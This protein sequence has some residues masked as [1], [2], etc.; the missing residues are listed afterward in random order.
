MR[1]SYISVLFYILISTFTTVAQIVVLDPTTAG[2]EDPVTII[3]DANQGNKELVGASKVYIHHGVVTDKPDGTAWKYVKGNWGADD[4]IGLMTR[5]EGEQNKW[6]FT[7]NPNIRSYFGVPASENIY[8]ISCVFRSADGTKKGTAP[9]GQFGWGTIASNLDIFINLNSGDFIQIN[10]PTGNYGLY[11][12]GQSQLVSATASSDVSE[13][14]LLIDEGNGFESKTMVT[15]GKT[16]Q[17]NYQ[18]TTSKTLKIRVT[19]KINGADVDFEKSYDVVVKN[20][21][22]NEPRPAGTLQGANYFSDPTKIRLSLLAPQK[23]LV[24]VVGDFTDWK[25]QEKYQMKKD[26]EYFWLD[27]DGLTPG[28]QYVYQYWIDGNLHI[29]DPYAQQIADPWNDKWIESFVFPNLPPYSREDLGIASVLQTSQPQ[30]TWS[31]QES[32][33][34]K[35]DVN[36]LVIYELHIRDFLGSHSYKDLTDTLSY[37]KRLGINAIELMPINEFEGNDSW[38]YNPSFYFAVDKYYGSKNDLKR[39]IDVAHQHGMAVILDIVL[40]H[41]FGQSPMVQMYFDKSANKPTANNPWFYRDYVGPFEWGYDFNHDSPYTKQFVDDVNTF[42]LREFHFDGF[43]FDFTKGFTSANHPFD[44]YNASRIGILKRMADKIR[45]FDPEAY[46]ILE[47]WGSAS[48]ETELANYGMKMWANRSYD[49]VPA[50]IGNPSTGSFVNMFANSH[51][52]FFNSHDERR[53]AEHCL[54]EGRSSGAYNVKT[55]EIMYERVK[56][57]AAFTYLQPGPKMI[58][59]FD[60]LGYDIDINLNGRT[61]RKPLPWGA[62]S[63]RY[64]ED[65]LRQHIYTTYQAVINL[66]NTITPQKLASATR[67]FTNT[68]NVRKITYTSNDFDLIVYGNFSMS[69][70]NFTPNFPKP[71]VWHQHMTG[72]S[73]VIINVNQ[74]FTLKPGEWHIYTTKKY[75]NGFPGAVEVFDNPVTIAPFPFTL[76]QEIT[77]TFDAK[78]A[79]KKGSAGLVGSDKVYYHS[80]TI[81]DVSKPNQWQTT[82]GTLTDDGLGVMTNLGNDL[83]Q[84]KIKARDYYNVPSGEDI[85]QLGMFFRDADNTNFGYGFRNS[86]IAV[87]V[88]STEPIVTINPAGFQPNTPITITFHADRGNRELLNATKIYMHSGVSLVNNQTPQI[89]GWQKVVGNWG[90]DDGVGAMTKVPGTNRWELKIT[91]KTYYNLTNT[92]FPYWITA[93]FRNAD[94]SIKGTGPQGPMENGFIDS[95]LDFFIKNAITVSNDEVGFDDLKIHPNPASDILFISS[96]EMEKL[97]GIIYN[98]LGQQMTGI[99]SADKNGIDISFLQP[100]TYWVFI[101]NNNKFIARSFVKF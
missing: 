27:I 76:D 100:G 73:I 6:K 86:V 75:S 30:Y 48:E 23:N 19:A 46:I 99:F 89:N 18:V 74:S 57:A 98:S 101:Q 32:E 80:G 40:N 96:N 61:G 10:Q 58:W 13:M 15:S 53:I 82:V 14:N 28:K 87:N 47:H 26:G 59:Q 64:Y 24:Y 2:P 25:V 11:D 71:G 44:G 95:Q 77:I 65:S 63:L 92:E 20:P 43:R 39:F 3:F 79:S 22:L 83:W 88:T 49:F 66:R 51:V 42:W 55:K 45:A 90:A 81:K 78:K 50:T 29:A 97:N 8:R 85:A 93:V 70:V 1:F 34:K 17:Y 54:T 68:G 5:V 84:I 36:H 94:G 31:P 21:N 35:P 41:A 91:P 7:I 52:S 72:D 16:I 60:E 69:N 56:M 33:W 62:G 37:L 12:A 38:G 4:G 9:A 67:S